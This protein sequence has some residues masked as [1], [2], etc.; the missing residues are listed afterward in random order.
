MLKGSGRL[1]ENQNT[2]FATGTSVSNDI[3]DDVLG[4]LSLRIVSEG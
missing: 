3:A 2:V 4:A 1:P